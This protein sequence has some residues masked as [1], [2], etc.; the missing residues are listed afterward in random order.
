MSAKYLNQ[1]ASD[2]TIMAFEMRVETTNWWQPQL[3][4]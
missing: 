1:Y 4:G 2:P 3:M